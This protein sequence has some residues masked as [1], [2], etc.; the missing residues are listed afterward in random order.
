MLVLCKPIILVMV[1]GVIILRVNILSEYPQ[2]SFMRHILLSFFI[3]RENL[4]LISESD[5]RYYLENF[6]N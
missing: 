1:R 3:S 2:W 5:G 6:R 4:S